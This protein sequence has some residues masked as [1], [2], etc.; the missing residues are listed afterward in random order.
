MSNYSKAPVIFYPRAIKQQHAMLPPLRCVLKQLPYTRWSVTHVG[1]QKRIYRAKATLKR[2][3]KPHVKKYQMESFSKVYNM[4]KAY[5]TEPDDFWIFE[6]GP[7]CKADNEIE[8]KPI[9]P[10]SNHSAFRRV[11]RGTCVM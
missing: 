3:T 9:L 11:K 10:Q 8:S 4:N 2:K 1:P 6:F 7:A 5:S